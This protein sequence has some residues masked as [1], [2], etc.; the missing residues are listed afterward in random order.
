ML[1][2]LLSQPNEVAAIA[3]GVSAGVYG[4][5][6]AMEKVVPGFRPGAN[7]NGSASAKIDTS[8]FVTRK[9]METRHRELREDISRMDDRLGK[10][11]ERI[12]TKLDRAI[13][14]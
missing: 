1:H 8:Q 13:A 11:L 4:A 5:F 12:E 7:G 14:K 2:L 10:D 6:R 3:G 9:E